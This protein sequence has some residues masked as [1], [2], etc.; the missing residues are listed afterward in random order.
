MDKAD[1]Y[2]LPSNSF[3]D[4][5]QFCC[6]LVEKALSHAHAMHI[7]TEEPIQNEALN[8][9]LWS[10][11]ASSFLPHAVG[12]NQHQEYPI[13]IDTL[14]LS[15]NNEGHRDLLILLN[16]NLP[17]NYSDFERLSILVINQEDKIQSARSLYK[18]L[19]S[20]GT[21]V[22]IHDLRK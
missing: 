8:D 4:Q 6:R 9:A 12:Q 2:L 14:S 11:K 17:S 20:A 18:Q 3:A 13:T 7:Q 22:N 15:A 5:I 21:D 16:T 19:K 10:F 1:L